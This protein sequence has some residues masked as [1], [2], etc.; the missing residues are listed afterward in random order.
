MNATA[1]VAFALEQKTL[2][3]GRSPAFCK[4]ELIN[5]G[6]TVIGT[7]AGLSDAALVSGV[8]FPSVNPGVYTM[9]CTRMDTAGAPIL[10]AVVSNQFT[11]TPPPNVMDVSMPQSVTVTLS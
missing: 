10:P 1:S 8:T 3:A 7:Q 11:V 5:S 4:L 9:S 2:P 6:G